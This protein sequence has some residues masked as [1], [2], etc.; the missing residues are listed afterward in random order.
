MNETRLKLFFKQYWIL[1]TL[2]ALKFI[3][4][5]A[6]INP[7]FE[8]HRDEFLY[9]DQAF[10]PAAGYISVPPFTSWM[11]RFIFIMGGGC[12]YCI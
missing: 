2:V 10:H 12:Y 4:Q 9:L 3:L 5:F 6:L 7:I 11:S 8:L 1:L